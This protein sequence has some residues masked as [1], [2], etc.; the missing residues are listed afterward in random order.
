VGFSFD[1]DSRWGSI[2]ASLI[3]ALMFG[4]ALRYWL[5]QKASRSWPRIDGKVIDARVV[6]TPSDGY[7]VE[8]LCQYHVGTEAFTVEGQL[9]GDFPTE[10]IAAGHARDR[11]GDAV[12]V[13]FDPADP[14]NA[15][16][17]PGALGGVTALAVLTGGFVGLGVWYVLKWWG[18]PT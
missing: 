14:T 13:A 16:L 3:S 4:T 10:L 2:A 1:F 9:D 17:E 18:N 15:T 6:G 12:D 8:Y 11:L 7:T 5:N